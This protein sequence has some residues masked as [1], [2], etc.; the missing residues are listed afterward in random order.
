MYMIVKRD[1]AHWRSK[2]TVKL[3]GNESST[4]DDFRLLKV[5]LRLGER[6]I[7]NALESLTRRC[8]A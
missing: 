6:V 1:L 7:L 2:S 3:K 5:S 8:A 4:A